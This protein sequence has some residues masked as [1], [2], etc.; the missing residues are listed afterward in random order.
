MNVLNCPHC[1]VNLVPSVTVTRYV[2]V[3]WLVHLL[4]IRE[5]P[6]SNIGIETGYPE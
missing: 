3:E 1:S 2:V 4:H 5:V 6:G